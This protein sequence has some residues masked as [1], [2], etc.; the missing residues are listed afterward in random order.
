M[1]IRLE[2][3]TYLNLRHVIAFLATFFLTGCGT[4]FKPAVPALSQATSSSEGTSEGSSPEESI[5][6]LVGVATYQSIGLYLPSTVAPL[7]PANENDATLEYRIKG[8]GAWKTG[9]PLWYDPRNSEY[10]G[11]LVNL[12]PGTR[13]EIRATL[14]DGK[15]HATELQTWAEKYPIAKTIV[16]P[17]NS[18]QTLEINEGGSEN[19]YVLYQPAGTGATI[20][21]AKMQDFNI[22]VKAKYV[23]IRG[24][25]LKGAKHS[26]ILLG[27]S[28]ASN[29]FDVTDVVIENNDISGWGSLGI[30]DPACL[31]KYPGA[32]QFGVNLQA[33]VFSRSKILER[34]TI[35]RN[36]IH[37]P[38]TGSNSWKEMNCNIKTFHPGGPQGISIFGSQGRIVVRYN[39]FYSDAAHYFNDSM[40]ETANFSDGGFPNK[41]SDIYGN[42]IRNCWD[43]GIESE[44][45][46]KN[47]RIWGNYIDQTYIKIALASTY[48]G[49]VYI[50][51]NVAGVS[52]TSPVDSYG[53]GFIKSRNSPDGKANWGGGRVYLFNNT[54]LLPAS[55]ASVSGFIN[56]FNDPNK[57]DSYRAYNNLI[58]ISASGKRSISEVYGTTNLYDYNYLDG[59]GSYNDT[60]KQQQHA[61]LGVPLL[62]NVAFSE[63]THSADFSLKTDSPG[64]DSGKVLPGFTDGFTGTSPDIGA[65]ESGTPAMEFGV[66][67]Y[68]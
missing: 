32:K 1:R 10:R 3:K 14:D 6:D 26:A 9:L 44:G 41:D 15:V 8:S 28:A 53:Q 5:N 63:T 21:V 64:I 31:A 27:P 58:Q 17:A 20:D 54:S 16:L 23:I 36:K 42:L 38:S 30:N 11:S 33:G 48:R 29:S 13:Y 57:L 4:G 51:R 66:E 50:F 34:V 22:V 47:V 61:I 37:H 18:N 67:A 65:Q 24:L 49:P 52:R 19:G 59:G 68:R 25:T 55:G 2:N 40:G 35:Q 39:E 12:K 7:H 43:D 60:A 45:A 56:E 62:D 46:N